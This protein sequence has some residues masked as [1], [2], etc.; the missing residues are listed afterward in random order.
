MTKKYNGLVDMT[1][2]ESGI[3]VYPNNVVVVENWKHTLGSAA[4]ALLLYGLPIVIPYAP[5][6]VKKQF[7]VNDIRKALPPVD[8]IQVAFDINDDLN[9]IFFE[10]ELPTPGM[11][12]QL[13][14]GFLVIAP[15]NWA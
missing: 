8:Q 14:G 6:K 7:Y 3:L 4:F 1:N 15:E 12:Y 10:N 11:C 2:Q 9:Q 5:M 13:E